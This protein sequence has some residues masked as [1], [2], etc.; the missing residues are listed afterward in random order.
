MTARA[1]VLV[2]FQLEYQLGSWG[3]DCT[4]AQLR[5]QAE[6]GAREAADRVVQVATEHAGCR[7]VLREIDSTTAVLLPENEP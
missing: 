6:R 3:E 4:V 5:A 1:K 7:V 2:T